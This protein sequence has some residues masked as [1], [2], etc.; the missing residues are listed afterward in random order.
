MLKGEQ[1]RRNWAIDEEDK[2]MKRQNKI[3]SKNL[4]QKNGADVF[5]C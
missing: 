2:K 5:F 4:S 1:E 3:N